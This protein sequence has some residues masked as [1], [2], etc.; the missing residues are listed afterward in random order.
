MEA[1]RKHEGFVLL[2]ERLMEGANSINDVHDLINCF[3][4][5]LLYKVDVESPVIVTLLNSFKVKELTLP[6]IISLGFLLKEIQL[7]SS[8]VAN[9]ITAL[10]RAFECQLET[11]LQRHNLAMICGAL[12]YALDNRLQQPTIKFISDTLLESDSSYWPCHHVLDLIRSMG[13]VPN[14]TKVGLKPLL[15]T[16]LD[17]LAQ[18]VDH[19][20]KDDLLH[21]MSIVQQRFSSQNRSW[22]N[23]NLCNKVAKRVIKENWSLQQTTV[24][25]LTFSSFP[26]VHDKLLQYLANLIVSCRVEASLIDPSYLLRPFSSTQFKPANFKKMVDVILSSPQLKFIESVNKCNKQLD[27]SITIN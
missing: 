18:L 13:T 6:Q 20:D 27:N 5:L 2:C 23:E 16:S 9:I 11:E 4:T 10:S 21:I 3:K 24:V 15:Q 14:V 19:C 22:F 1:L 25:S 12:N 17:R 26:F 7:S 8:L